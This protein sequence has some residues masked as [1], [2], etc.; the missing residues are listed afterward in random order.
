M[1]FLAPHIAHVPPSGIRRIFELALGLDDVIFL[2]VGE[3]DVAVAAPILA[4]GSAA[5]LGDETN[6]GPNGGLSPLREA[7]VAKLARENDI[8]VD[9]DRVWVTVGG[10]H[11]LYLS[12][13]LTLAPGDEVLIP[14]PGYSTFAMNAAM[15][16]AV[17]VPYP[18]LAEAGFLPDVEGLAALVTPRTRAIIINSPSN[19][20][21]SVFPRETL[22][23]LLAFARAHD[24]WII[25]DEVYE[26]FNYEH[27]HTSIASLDTEDRVFS[28]FS[29]SK[30]YALTGA[31]VGY[32][33]T[34]PGLGK[35]MRTAQEAMISC[36]S[37]PA[38]LAAL[39]A[40]TGSQEHVAASALHYR[41]NL[42]AATALLGERGIRYL[43]PTGAFYIWVDM[44]HDTSGDVSAWAERFLMEQRVAVAPGSAFGAQGE[45]WIRLC[46]AADRDQLLEGIRRLPPPPATDAGSY[47][48]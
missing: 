16:S 21:G 12:M 41:A 5:W 11:A 24:L 43:D 18:L 6:Y 2:A 39:A 29:L 15:I 17:S 45:G 20:L 42:A 23:E 9:I 3:P 46:V 26:A 4:A 19:P 47:L 48:R 38:Q 7:I 22:A 10:M 27:P 8:H 25:S 28:V 37:T 32:L 40:I 14:D 44:S 1:P 33:V 36:V 35:V 13:S 30:T 34:P 31:R